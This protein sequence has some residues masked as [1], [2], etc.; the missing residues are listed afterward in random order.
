MKNKNTHIQSF[1]IFFCLFWIVIV[2]VRLIMTLNTTP[3]KKDK[4]P[5]GQICMTNEQYNK[6]I[7]TR[8]MTNVENR[9]AL[10]PSSYTRERDM[11]VLNDPLYPAVNR[12]DKGSFESV[13]DKTIERRINVPTRQP[14][15]DSYRLVGYITNED[16]EIKTWKLFAKQTDR[17]RGDFYILPGNKNY[18][19]KVQITDSIV[20]GEKLR[21]LDTI[22]NEVTFN[23][24]LLASTPY[25]FTELPKGDLRDELDI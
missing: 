17:N 15:N 9:P 24:P 12:A 21:D 6:L 18:D 19:M 13:V 16:D 25:K 4:C 10:V 5:D 3:V 20:V 8:G 1:I 11:R 23:S 7:D 2:L 22:P 14:Y